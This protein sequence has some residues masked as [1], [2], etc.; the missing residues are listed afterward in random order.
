MLRKKLLI[1]GVFFGTCCS[2]PAMSQEVPEAGGELDVTL[3]VIED[4]EDV[5]DLINNIELPPQAE[6]IAE[7]TM[8]AVMETLKAAETVGE[9]SDAEREA[10]I[11]EALARSQEL[12]ANASASAD[13][14][15]EEAL[16][17]AEATREIIEEAVKSALS[18]AELDGLI[19]QMMQDIIDSLPDDIKSELPEDLDEMLDE[20][21]NRLREQSE[22]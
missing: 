3:T 18:G 21:R 5:Q 7:E 20:V 13:I 14:A 9:K 15:N 10:M 8:A 11:R 4:S 19:D 16:R 12:I 6:A 1:A 17:A 22:E 2:L